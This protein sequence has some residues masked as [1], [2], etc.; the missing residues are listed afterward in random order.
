MLDLLHNNF[1]SEMM[2]FRAKTTKR[3]E[4]NTA[5]SWTNDELFAAEK[6]SL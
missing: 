6:S 1:R 2:I 3:E 4:V 5:Y